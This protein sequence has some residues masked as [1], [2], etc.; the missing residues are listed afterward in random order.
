MHPGKSFE[1]AALEGAR[2]LPGDDCALDG[3]LIRYHT[4]KIR[5]AWLDPLRYR[6]LEDAAEAIADHAGQ[7]RFLLGYYA[8]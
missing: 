2:G 3:D 1:Q 8:L 4:E 6:C 5:E 7:I